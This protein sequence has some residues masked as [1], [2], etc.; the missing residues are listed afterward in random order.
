MTRD[1]LIAELERSEI[2]FLE[3]RDLYDIAIIG[4]AE[5]LD[6]PHAVYNTEGVLQALMQSQD[7]DAEA[8][9][10]WYEFN[11]AEAFVGPGAPIFIYVCE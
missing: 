2:T 8:A 11:I 10:D 4:I 1:E 7:W 5:Q 3:P 6:G 9:R